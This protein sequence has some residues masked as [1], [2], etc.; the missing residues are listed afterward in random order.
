MD[1]QQFKPEEISVEISRD[2]TVTMESKHEINS[3]EKGHIYRHLVNEFVLPQSCNINKIESKLS[4]D[5]I[6]T[7]T[8]PKIEEE[9]IEQQ[10]IPIMQ[11]GEPAKSKSTDKNEQQN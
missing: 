3:D 1:V 9:Q 7:I 4:S 8:A 6:L 5:G 11:T 2:R 10:N